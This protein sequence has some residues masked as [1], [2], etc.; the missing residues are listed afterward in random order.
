LA[1]QNPLHRAPHRDDFPGE[2]AARG[3]ARLEAFAD[4]V[5]AIAFTLP[6]VEIKVPHGDEPES[7]GADR[8]EL[9]EKSG[10]LDRDK[11]QFAKSE[12]AKKTGNTEQT[13]GRA[14]GEDSGENH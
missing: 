13:G 8:D 14:P 6:I 2:G 10:L 5:F 4:A 3:T 1:E 11:E 7:G 12:A 9:R